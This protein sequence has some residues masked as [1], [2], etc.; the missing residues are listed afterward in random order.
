MVEGKFSRY[1]G[2]LSV[3]YEFDEK[4]SHP[5][6]FSLQLIDREVPT[7]FLRFTDFVLPEKKEDT[8]KEKAVVI[9]SCSLFEGDRR[10]CRLNGSGS[11]AV[12]C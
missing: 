10:L 8:V 9:L 1:R 12:R 11:L 6:L 7:S 4:F 3:L 2:I 5:I